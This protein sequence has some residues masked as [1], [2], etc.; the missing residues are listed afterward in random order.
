MIISAE[1]I[2]QP[3][4]GVYRERIYDIAYDWNSGDWT[5]IKFTEDD[6]EWCGEF[7]GAYAGVAVSK[8]HGV[9]VVLTSNHLYVLDMQSAEVRESISGHPY[10]AMTCSPLDDIILTDGYEL[11]M[12]TRDNIAS[13]QPISTPIQPD[14]LEFLEW[15]D[16]VLKMTCYEFLNWSNRPTLYLDSESMKWLDS[17]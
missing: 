9:V 6:H 15:Q 4:A 7:R 14:C 16:N 13:I 3:L 10:T 1:A 17:E 2:E 11:A 5:W 8:K 12:F